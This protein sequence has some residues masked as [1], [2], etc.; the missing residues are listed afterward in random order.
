MSLKNQFKIY[1]SSILNF[2]QFDKILTDFFF[3]KL[4]LIQ[5]VQILF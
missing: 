3:K 5:K 1:I 2:E 4:P